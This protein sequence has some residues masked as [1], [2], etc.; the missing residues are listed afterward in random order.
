MLVFLGEELSCLLLKTLA[1][2]Q[3]QGPAEE[4]IDPFAG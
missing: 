4:F 3:V 2:L 1:P